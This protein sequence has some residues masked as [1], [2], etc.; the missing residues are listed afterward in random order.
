MQR[1]KSG[2]ATPRSFLIGLVCDRKGT[3]RI[4]GLSRPIAHIDG[5]VWYIAVGSS[6]PGCAQATKGVG[7]HA[8][9]GIV[10]W[11]KNVK[12]KPA[13]P[14]LIESISKPTKISEQKNK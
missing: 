6:Y 12:I 10:S 7:V 3:L 5:A 4:T 8:L 11:V 14:E 9:K 1:R 2:L 13:T